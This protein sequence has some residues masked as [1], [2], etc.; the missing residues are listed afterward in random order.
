MIL[1]IIFVLDYILLNILSIGFL[2]FI[3]KLNN[4][5]KKFSEVCNVD[6]SSVG[7]K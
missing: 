4:T 1:L 5:K 6:L 7:V 3:I 2:V